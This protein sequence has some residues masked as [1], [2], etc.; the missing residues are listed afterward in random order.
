MNIMIAPIV[1]SGLLCLLQLENCKMS[2]HTTIKAF[3]FSKVNNSL[4]PYD[5]RVR[6]DQI[7]R[8]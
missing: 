2:W 3:A 7:I 4:S 1:L 6:L 8:M 5:M